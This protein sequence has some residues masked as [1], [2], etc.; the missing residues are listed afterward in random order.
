M[1]KLRLVLFATTCF[2][3]LTSY[4][5]VEQTEGDTICYVLKRG[6]L[7]KKSPCHFE[8]SFGGGID[9][10]VREYNLEG[11]IGQF[12][13]VNNSSFI[14]KPNSKYYTEV[15]TITLNNKQAIV[16][17][18]LLPNFTKFGN[19]PAE[20]TSG[21]NPNLLECIQTK[22]TNPKQNFEICVPHLGYY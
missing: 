16:I 21:K 22:N 6:K 4:A 10:R 11:K 2:L 12:K 13:V 17:Y 3:P 15:P 5:T 14:S 9:Y 1:K 19:T 8:G 7:L 18:R 20:K